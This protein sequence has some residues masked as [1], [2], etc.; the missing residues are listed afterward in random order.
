[1]A[2]HSTIDVSQLE[3]RLRGQIDEFEARFDKG[4]EIVVY[5]ASPSCD[6]SPKVAAELAQRG[7]E[8]VLDYEADMSGWRER[9]HEVE[10]KAA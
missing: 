8:R 5:C 7:F 9:G 1:M 10:G 4:K 2:R 6:A 3:T